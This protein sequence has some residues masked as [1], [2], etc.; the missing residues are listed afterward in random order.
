M[1]RRLFVGAIHGVMAVEE[2]DALHL[3]IGMRLQMLGVINAAETDIL[4]VWTKFR[5]LGLGGRGA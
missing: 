1:R 3:L 4:P 2:E 5:Q